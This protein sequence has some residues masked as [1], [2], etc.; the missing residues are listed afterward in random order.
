MKK[1]ILLLS[2]LA[3]T[4]GMN[5]QTVLPKQRDKT[6]KWEE[7]DQGE[8]FNVTYDVGKNV[9]VME[10]KAFHNALMTAVITSKYK[11]KNKLSFR[12]I[13][14][15]LYNTEKDGV[16]MTVKFAGNNAY[17]QP[18]MMTSYYSIED[19][20]GTPKAVHQFTN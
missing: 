4:L 7:P 9:P 20:D 3:F 2:I 19:I 1:F 5:A 18:G 14:V 8:T 13:R 16:M 10:E 11:L 15:F 12:P 17:G 6:F